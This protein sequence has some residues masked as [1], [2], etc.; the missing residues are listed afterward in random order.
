MNVQEELA[1]TKAFAD[2]AVAKSKAK[3]AAATR[4]ATVSQQSTE[5]RVSIIEEWSKSK[6]YPKGLAETPRS[7]KAVGDAIKDIPNLSFATLDEAVRGCI[8]RNELDFLSTGEPV[9]KIVYRD[10]PKTDAQIAREKADK[11]ALA[12]FR[13][14]AKTEFDRYEESQKA[15]EAPISQDSMDL[16]SANHYQKEYAQI[17]SIIDHYT[18]P[19]SPAVTEHRKNLLRA[20][21]ARDEDGYR[22]GIVELKLVNNLLASFSTE[23]GRPHEAAVQEAN[24][25]LAGTRSKTVNRW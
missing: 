19:K 20:V 1:R 2:E 10:K 18:Y 5:E 24:K 13:L 3:Q 4:E 6:W 22:N 25:A 14:P 15:A 21:V 23:P 8:R 17:A 11:A 12:G 9:E 16:A 7:I